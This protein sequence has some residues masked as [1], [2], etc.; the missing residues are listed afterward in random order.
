MPSGA[1]ATSTRARPERCGWPRRA[2]PPRPGALARYGSPRVP[3]YPR[4]I[5]C[6]TYAEKCPRCQQPAS[7]RHNVQPRRDTMY[8]LA[9]TLCTTSPRHNVQPRRD[10]MYNLAETQC[11][12]SPRHNVQPRRGTMYNL[13]ETQCTTSPRHYVQPRR[14]TMC[15]LAEAL[16]TTS[17]RHE[18]PVP[19]AARELERHPLFHPPRLDGLQ[20]VR[21]AAHPLATEV[22]QHQGERGPHHQPPCAC[23]SPAKLPHRDGG[24]SCLLE[25]PTRRVPAVICN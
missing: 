21:E 25:V 12:T 8:N 5:R 23:A 14:G 13:A 9:E 16:C 19:A 22:P 3:C 2:R 11:T 24:P 10:T 20:L 1:R 4:E 6:R 15:I 7:P 18:F 17:P